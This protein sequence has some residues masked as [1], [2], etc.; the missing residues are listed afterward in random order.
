M[1]SDPAGRTIET[2]QG[3][4]R[5]FEL[6]MR[7]GRTPPLEALEQIARALGALYQDVAS[8]H[9]DPAACPCG[10]VPAG[11][12]LVRLAEALRSGSNRT[13]AVGRDLRA[14]TPAGRA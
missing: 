4:A 10:W 13:A 11:D 8:A 12:D 9:R 1:S 5:L 6:A 2:A 14:M 3:L 7:D